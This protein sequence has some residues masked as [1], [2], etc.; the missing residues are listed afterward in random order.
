M[1]VK[2]W[3]PDDDAGDEVGVKLA[4]VFRVGVDFNFIIGDFKRENASFGEYVAHKE[5]S[6]LMRFF[7]YV[8]DNFGVVGVFASNRS[9]GLLVILGE[10]L[11][12]EKYI[13]E[14]WI[15]Y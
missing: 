13:N 3:L 12:K 7:K 9:N 10:L 5:W 8:E 14:K 6:V 15:A 2:F 4:S 11:H 1:S